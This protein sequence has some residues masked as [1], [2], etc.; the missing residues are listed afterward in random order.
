MLLSACALAACNIPK[1]YSS[2]SVQEDSVPSG[3]WAPQIGDDLQIQFSGDF[4]FHEDVEVYDLDLFDTTVEIIEAIHARGKRVLCYINVGAW[5]DWRPDATQYPS[6]LLG[7]DYEGWPGEKWLDI[8]RTKEL[9]PLI[10]ARFDLCRE[11]GF[12]GVEPDNLDGYQ[13][14]TGFELSAD[15]Q[16][17]FNLWLTK[18]AHKRG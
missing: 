10:S 9:N 5:E 18:E 16:L 17:E 2:A 4:E 14:E 1:T 3:Y 12:D 7:N 8:R 15:D 13:N 11:K 6:A